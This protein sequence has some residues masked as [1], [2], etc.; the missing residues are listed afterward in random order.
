MTVVTAR[1]IYYI[2]ILHMEIA[3]ANE[4]RDQDQS[5]SQRAEQITC[6]S[7][8]TVPKITAPQVLYL[9]G[10]DTGSSERKLGY[11]HFPALCQV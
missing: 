8:L 2:I 4:E 1:T 6:R 3:L 9:N 7:D 10:Q 5:P 11:P